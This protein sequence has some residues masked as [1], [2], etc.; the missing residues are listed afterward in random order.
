MKI[1]IGKE[2]FISIAILVIIVALLYSLF[3]TPQGRQI[4]AIRSQ[5]ISGKELLMARKAKGD[6]LETLRSR[7]R[8]WKYELDAVQNR[9]LNEN[10]INSF[11]KDLTRLAEET[12]NN[13]KT[14]EGIYILT[15]Q[16]E[17]FEIWMS[18]ITVLIG[19]I[20]LGFCIFLYRPN[21]IR[22]LIERARLIW[23]LSF[24]KKGY[25]RKSH[26]TDE[27]FKNLTNAEH[28]I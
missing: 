14:I 9:F 21:K 7:N 18:S 20:F 2:K 12:G 16:C 24:L 19:A 26:K 6:E 1:K 25:I 27:V 22:D 5:Y 10:E 3:M 17:P 23:L 15:N 8:E 13:L 11:L 28:I 4:K